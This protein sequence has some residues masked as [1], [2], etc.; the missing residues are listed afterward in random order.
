MSRS[1]YVSNISIGRDN[2]LGDNTTFAAKIKILTSV[3]YSKQ[4]RED[5][6]LELEPKEFQNAT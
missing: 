5:A 4:R 3:L 2:A 1:K 6:T